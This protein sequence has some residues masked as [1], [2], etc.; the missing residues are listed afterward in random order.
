MTEDYSPITKRLERLAEEAVFLKEQA[1]KISN[2][3]DLAKRDPGYL[4]ERSMQLAVE[5][6]LDIGRNIIAI[7]KLPKPSNNDEIFDILVEA[8][9]L[10]ENLTKRIKGMGGFRNI[11][12]HGYLTVD[13]NQIYQNL[14]RLADFEDFAI[15]IKDY[16]KSRLSRQLS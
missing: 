1:K 3:K 4:V 2:Q 16:I 8:G 6:V 13:Y 5:A 9:I 12:V 7:E 14:K 15:E 10:S 11:L